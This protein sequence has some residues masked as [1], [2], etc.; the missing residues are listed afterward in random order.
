[1]AGMRLIR[2]AVKRNL[3]GHVM[4]DER[5]AAIA[6]EAEQDAYSM[7]KGR[8]TRLKSTGKLKPVYF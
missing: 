7:L 2:S 4:K 8:T 5:M 6:V 1:M 3:Y